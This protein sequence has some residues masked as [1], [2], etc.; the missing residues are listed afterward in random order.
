M[1]IRKL[2]L[3]GEVKIQWIRTLNEWPEDSAIAAVRTPLVNADSMPTQSGGE[4]TH[5]EVLVY[6]DNAGRAQIAGSQAYCRQCRGDRC[7]QIRI[8]PG[9]NDG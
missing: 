5:V 1:F 8:A 4:I 3:W 9:E 2:A 6:R 7:H